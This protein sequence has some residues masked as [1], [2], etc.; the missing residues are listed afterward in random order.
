MRVVLF[1][2]NHLGDNVVF[3]PVVQTLRRLRPDW[4]ITVVTAEPEVP[5][6]AGDLTANR[7]WTSPSRLAFHHAWRQPWV[8]ARWWARL[9]AERPAAI[10]LSYDQC[11]SAHLLAQL[12]G[13]N[14]RVGA[15]LPFLRVVG[16]MTHEVPRTPSHKIADW[17]WTM[18]RT[19]AE[20]LE[21]RD[22]PAQPPAPALGHLVAS[23]PA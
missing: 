21:I 20:A 13:A 6:Y 3:L 11:N 12:S 1:K 10:L 22:W 8:W 4:R 16:S 17:N 14:V 19:L 15:R 7:I 9:R 2:V 18:G 23:P 5:L